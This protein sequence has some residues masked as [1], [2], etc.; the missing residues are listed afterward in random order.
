MVS[1]KLSSKSETDSSSA[2]DELKADQSYMAE[3]P[4]FHP[5]TLCLQSDIR[6]NALYAQL[7]SIFEQKDQVEKLLTMFNICVEHGAHGIAR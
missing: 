4:N 3:H 1:I 7:Q 6:W 5:K 2:G